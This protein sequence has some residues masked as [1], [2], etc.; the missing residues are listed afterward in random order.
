MGAQTG[1]Q[2]AVRQSGHP[3]LG[4][5]LTTSIGT[6]PHRRAGDAV[7][8]VLERQPG[9]PAVPQLPN[10][11]P[12][13]RRLPQAAWGIGGVSVQPDGSITLDHSVLDVEAPFSDPTFS[14]EPY[15]TLQVFLRRIADRTGPA[16]FQLTG[17]VT[18]GLALHAAGVN[19]NIAFAV[20]STVVQSRASD[21]LATVARKA[22]GVHPVV[23][24][25][26]PG[27]RDCLDPAFPLRPDDA[28][29]LVSAVLATLE[30]NATTGLRCTPAT[31]P[32]ASDVHAID[33]PLVLQAGPQILAVSIEA[34]ADIVA[35][36]S[37]F[38]AFLDRGGFV[39]WGAV[40]TEGPVGLASGVTRQWRALSAL[41]CEMVQ[42]GCDV[43]R[44][45]TQALVTPAGGLGR[46]KVSQA[47]VLF[48]QV[49]ELAQRLYD[50]ATGIRLS[51]GA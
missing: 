11:S 45:R 13:E 44:L 20:A 46:H 27:L 5:G 14:G 28:I 7:R 30:A 23:F 15:R 47:A 39:A 34:P 31:F 50:Q 17:P 18:L 26:E 24:V 43:T 36:A 40:P 48:R 25:D 4:I 42:A 33:W 9:L 10:R 41:W 37:A 8:F 6:L 1:S 2:Q 12:M 51:V 32:P 16:K 19:A 22:P 3:S 49:D 29:D 38:D 35:A 21:L